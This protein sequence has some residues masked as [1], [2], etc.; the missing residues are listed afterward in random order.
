[1][2]WMV[3]WI[4]VLQLGCAGSQLPETP[5]RL[6]RETQALLNKVFAQD[7]T[8]TTQAVTASP[9]PSSGDGP[10]AQ[11]L[12]ALSPE[13]K[14]F[15][16]S[17]D[18][19]LAPAQRFRRI[20]RT[21]RQERFEL[22]YDLDRTTTA[23]EAFALRRG[24]CISFAALVVALAREVGM[25]AHFNQVHAPMERRATSGGDGRQLVQDI[26]HINAEVT[27][28]WTTRVIE[29]NFEPRF[30]YRHQ[31]LTDATVQALYLNNRALEVAREKRHEEALSML[32]EALLLTPNASL[33]WNSLGYI[34]RQGGNLELAQLS[35]D[36]ALELDSN[37]SAARR[38]LRNVY[39]LQSLRALSQSELPTDSNRGS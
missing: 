20:L 15:V 9:E 37:N 39:R 36:Q 16:E 24:N 30:N 27:F 23:A 3:I 25:E 4:T 38:N 32:K 33:L 10:R 35:Y 28:G 29:F 34:H 7:L 8:D 19:S 18:P 1:M 31:Q 13:M 11:Q 5:E 22:E 17:I 21:L 2:R 6:D 14:E 12:L 26:L